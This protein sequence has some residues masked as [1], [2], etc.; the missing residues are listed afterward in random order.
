M[1]LSETYRYLINHLRLRYDERESRSIALLLL[2]A[3]GFTN[4]SVSLTPSSEISNEQRT[5]LEDKL[6]EIISGKPVQYV[7]EKTEFYGLTFMVNRHVLIPRPETEELVDMIIKE[8]K[9]KSPVI[10]DIGTGSGCI[11]I[12]L[13]NN[14][15]NARVFAMDISEEAL[16]VAKTN[17][18]I[19]KVSVDFFRD[20]ILNPSFRLD[21]KFFDIMVSNPPYVLQEDLAQMK[22][23]VLNYEPG[24]ALMADITD[25]LLFYRQIFKFSRYHLRNNGYIYCEINEKLGRETVNLAHSFGFTDV[26]V[27]KDINGKERILRVV[28]TTRELSV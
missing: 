5:F 26:R 20:D 27:S 11:A 16:K 2:E 1:Q 7:L 22:D 21:K 6:K 15:I 3:Q 9:I 8:N 14:I 28:E 23:N 17:S 18:D 4:L 12:S 10:L 19:N 25:P 24:N 13:A